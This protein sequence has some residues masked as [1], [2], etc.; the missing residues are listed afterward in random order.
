[1]TSKV[2]LAF[3]EPPELVTV[4]VYT[5]AGCRL[6]ETPEIEPLRML[7]LRPNGNSG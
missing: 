2:M 7:K 3:A 6:K 5:V 4:T 1:M